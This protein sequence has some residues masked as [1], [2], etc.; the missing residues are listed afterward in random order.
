MKRVPKEASIW[1]I[2]GDIFVS[3][4]IRQMKGNLHKCKGSKIDMSRRGI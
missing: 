4:E 2:E 3:S 1:E